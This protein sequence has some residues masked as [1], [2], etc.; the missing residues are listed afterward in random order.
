[1]LC[2][3]NLG[4]NP[5]LTFHLI[6]LFLVKME[7]GTSQEMSEEINNL[8]QTIAG[9]SSTM[10]ERQSELESSSPSSWVFAQISLWGWF[11]WLARISSFTSDFIF[12]AHR[13]Q[14]F[15]PWGK[16]IGKD[17]RKSKKT[18][19]WTNC[20]Q[21]GRAVRYRWGESKKEIFIAQLWRKWRWDIP[22][23]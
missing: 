12:T 17:E 5:L 15:E 11:M 8:A 6:E 18:S 4:C 1:M 22:E 14:T 19:G 21:S 13:L 2:L 3:L 23:S 20:G 9:L 10:R 7:K 16:E